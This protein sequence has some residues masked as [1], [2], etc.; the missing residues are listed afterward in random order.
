MM[1]KLYVR[2]DGNCVVGDK[3]DCLNGIA[4][5]GTAWPVLSRSDTDTIKILFYI[6]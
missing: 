3:C 6:K 5:P 4:V 2:D 1:G